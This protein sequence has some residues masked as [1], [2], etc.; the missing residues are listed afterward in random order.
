MAPQSRSQSMPVRGLYITREQAYSG[1]DW[2]HTCA[3]GVSG[4]FASVTREQAYSGRD[5]LHTCAH[6]VSGEFASVLYKYTQA[7]WATTKK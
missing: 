2:L 5:W 6:G 1:R 7:V 4:E 3:H